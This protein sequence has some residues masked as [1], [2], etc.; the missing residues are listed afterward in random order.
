MDQIR[1]EERLIPNIII[2][3]AEFHYIQVEGNEHDTNTKIKTS[4]TPY[5][6]I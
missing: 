5:H 1:M 4:K 2:N 6:Y 3:P